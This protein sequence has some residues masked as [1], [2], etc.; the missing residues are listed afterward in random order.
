MDTRLGG[1]SQFRH[2]FVEKARFAPPTCPLFASTYPTADG[3]AATTRQGET[4]RELASQPEGLRCLAL[5]VSEPA[6]RFSRDIWG[7]L[8]PCHMH[9]SLHLEATI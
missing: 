2:A 8:G 1:L 7:T 4:K 9:V 5:R 3:G 6:S